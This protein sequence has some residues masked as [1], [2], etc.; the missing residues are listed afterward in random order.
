MSEYY[1]TSHS[2][3][4][5]GAHTLAVRATDQ[6]EAARHQVQSFVNAEHREEIIFTKGA[7]EAIN[8]VA[9]S[10]GQRLHPGDEIILTVA[11][12]HANLVPWQMLAQRTG[13]VL[14]FI[15]LTDSMEL[16]IDQYK[17]LLSSKTKLV[18]FAHASNVLGSLNP[19]KEMVLEAKKVG[20]VVLLDACQSV[21]HMPVDVQALGIDFLVASSHK[22]CGPTGIGFL[23]G[24][25]VLLEY[26]PPV[27]GVVL[28]LEPQLLQRQ[29]D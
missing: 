1:Q 3:V 11:E 13:A 28:K 25:K 16:D 29:L 8:L 4:H 2:N 19:V 14:K 12:H 17:S 9:L 7:T 20:A 21:P 24:K 22:M 5:R 6:F 27:M 18:A 15:G 10:W 26:M 23:Y